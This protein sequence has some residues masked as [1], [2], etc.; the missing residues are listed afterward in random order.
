M[1]TIEILVNHPKCCKYSLKLSKLTQTRGG[2]AFLFYHQMK[3]EKCVVQ[4]VCPYR[5]KESNAFLGLIYGWFFLIQKRFLIILLKETTFKGAY[6][7]FCGIRTS[8][9]KIWITQNFLYAPV[10]NR[11]AFLIFGTVITLLVSHSMLFNK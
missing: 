11:A 2:K 10:Y 6:K 9:L 3:A 8:H 1:S 7:K 4:T 5:E